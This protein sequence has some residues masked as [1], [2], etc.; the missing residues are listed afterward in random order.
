MP[1]T[2]ASLYDSEVVR[3]AYPGFANLVL[4]SIRAA[5]PRPETPAY[6]D[7]SLAIRS[8]LHPASDIELPADLRELRE[9]IRAAL[10]S[11][12]LVVTLA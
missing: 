6:A 2:K 4:E 1:P 9:T 10:I 7:V 8:A 11:T 12:A 3:E 5:T